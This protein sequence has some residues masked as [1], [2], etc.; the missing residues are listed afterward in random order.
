MWDFVSEGNVQSQGFP[1]TKVHNKGQE[2][3]SSSILFSLLVSFLLQHD[4]FA[5]H[6]SRTPSYMYYHK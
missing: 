3:I 6:T 1:R 5:A 4:F 2:T